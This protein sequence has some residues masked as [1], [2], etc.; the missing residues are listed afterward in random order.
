MKSTY[1]DGLELGK[2]KYIYA[3]GLIHCN[4]NSTFTTT[5][6]F[7]SDE[8]NMQNFPHRNDSWVREQ[9]EA[10]DGHVIVAADYGQLEMCGAA[11]CS[12]DPILIK[13][14]WN[15]VDTHMVWAAKLAEIYP[16]CVGGDFNDPEVAK[17]FRSLFKNKITFPAIYGASNAS[18]AGYINI[19]QCYIDDLMDIFWDSFKGIKKWQSDLLCSYR[20]T[21]YVESPTGRRRHHPLTSNEAINAPIQCLGSE[22]VVDAMNRLSFLAASTNQW[23]LHPRL[24]VH[25]DLTFCVPLKKF[26]ESVATI[27]EIMLTPTFGKII[28]VP[29]SVSVEYGKNWYN[30]FTIGKFWSHKD[31]CQK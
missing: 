5:G 24:N 17:S 6:R 1:V 8:P 31:I 18:M 19:D 22:I 3:D 9:I 27:V 4:F 10:P 29:L 25:D 21:G 11:M 30:M 2:G 23:H 20:E 26:D 13:D 16:L 15:D 7:S 28:N 14:L 12:K